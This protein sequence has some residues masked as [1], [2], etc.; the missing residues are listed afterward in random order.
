M[1]G[2]PAQIEHLN[3]PCKRTSGNVRVRSDLWRVGWM[4]TE[5]L[6]DQNWWKQISILLV[7]RWEGWGELSSTNIPVR[8]GLMMLNREIYSKSPVYHNG[9]SLIRSVYSQFNWTQWN[10][11]ANFKQTGEILMEFYHEEHC[12]LRSICALQSNDKFI[13]QAYDLMPSVNSFQELSNSV[14]ITLQSLVTH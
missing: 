3:Q 10:A 1:A 6:I 8:N 14:V 4:R 2:I 11:G 5:M 12:A 13:S 9:S 7:L